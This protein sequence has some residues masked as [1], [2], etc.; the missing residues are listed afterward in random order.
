MSK[1]LGNVIDPRDVITGATPQRRQ[2]PH[3]I[4]E[5]GAD[6]LRMAL[7]AH[8]VHGNV[9]KCP[10]MSPTVSPTMSHWVLSRTYFIYYILS[11]LSILYQIH[12]DDLMSRWVLS[13]LA[14]S[15]LEASRAL[16][17][18]ELQGALLAVQ[19]F[20]WRNFCDVYLVCPSIRP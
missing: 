9:P 3:G 15:A 2:F 18:L 13:R 10:Q 12:V 6:A 14:G 11:I 5:C 4:P 19:T 1:S 8:N 7:C 20:W 17:A 16:A